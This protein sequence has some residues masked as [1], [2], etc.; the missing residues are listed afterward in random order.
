MAVLVGVIVNMEL[1]RGCSLTTFF[2]DLFRY[3]LAREGVYA[4]SGVS[5]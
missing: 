3:P 4:P 5:G 2:K 1:V